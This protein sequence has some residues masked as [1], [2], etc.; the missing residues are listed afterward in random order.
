[1]SKG[2]VAEPSSRAGGSSARTSGLTARVNPDDGLRDGCRRRD[3]LVRRQTR[4]GECNP[5][6]TSKNAAVGLH[7]R[8]LAHR[9]DVRGAEAMGHRLLV[10]AEIGKHG[11]VSGDIKQ[12]CNDPTVHDTRGVDRVRTDADPNAGAW[13]CEIDGVNVDKPKH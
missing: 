11:G 12:G 5:A 4:G 10:V 13:I 7:D 8:W 6:S 2:V 3:A 9:G 1:R